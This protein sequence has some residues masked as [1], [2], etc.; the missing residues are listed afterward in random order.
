MDRQDDD[1]KSVNSFSTGEQPL[2]P[3]FQDNESKEDKSAK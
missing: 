2:K 1:S 3:H